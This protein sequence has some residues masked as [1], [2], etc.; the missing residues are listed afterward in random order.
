MAV[1]VPATTDLI[2]NPLH[3]FASWTYTWSLWWLDTD[4]HNALM[5]LGDVDT[6]MA[7]SPTYPNSFVVAED[8]GA[9]ADKRFPMDKYATLPPSLQAMATP[10]VLGLNYQIQ[11]VQIST[12]FGL[13][14]TTEHSNLLSGTMT[15]LE[16]YGVTFI[17]T[18]VAASWDGAQFNNY[19]QHPMML[20]LDFHGYD[21]A[22]NI[23]P[24]TATNIFRKRFPITMTAIK[25]NVS[26]KGAEYKIQFSPAGHAGHQEE[27][28][29]TPK[30]FQITAG[31]VKEFVDD[32]KQQFNDYYITEVKRGNA[33]YGD[34]IDFVIDADIASSTIVNPKET[35]LTKA[36][37]NTSDITLTKN[38]WAIPAGTSIVK[39]ITRLIS[40]TSWLQ[41]EQLGQDGTKA[42]SNQTNIT[43][44]IKTVASAK[45]QGIG[46]DNLRNTYPREFKYMV[47]QYPTWKG[48]H[49][50]MPTMPD[51]TPHTIK[52]YN[53]LYTGQNIDI[54]DLKLQFDTTYYT[55][56]LSYNKQLAA[57]QTT[58]QTGGDIALTTA[59]S[60]NL[61]PSS[62]GLGIP[63]L[64]SIPTL[65]PFRVKNLVNDR[66]ITSHMNTSG[67]PGA[68]VAADVMQST[69]S[70][71]N[72]DMLKVDLTIVGDPTLLKQDDWAYIPN[73]LTSSIFNSWDT[74]GQSD[75]ARSYGHV[76]TD[77]GELIVSLTINT[78]F[79][80]DTDYEG[81][82]LVYP[83]PWTKQSLFSGQYT[84]L[85]VDSTF[86]SGK[87]E[88]VLHLARYINQDFNKAF[89][90]QTNTGRVATIDPVKTNQANQTQ[91]NSTNSSDVIPYD[92][93]RA[94][95][96]GTWS[97]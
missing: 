4:D 32:F 91:S 29:K 72:G 36:D 94:G 51:S 58:A 57:T 5:D 89:A 63:E 75:F 39:V 26:N 37:S 3:Q 84:I 90:S 35:P 61:M 22:G 46:V 68:I 49:P 13:N 82:G 14:A 52:S 42:D 87:F 10:G 23:L 9:Y 85:K 24:D 60:I 97:I 2:P 34:S 64:L 86:R 31:T 17:D 76:R 71:L 6:A 43:N 15:V 62:L 66:N 80:I 77:A 56:V 69:F 11:D 16:P 67:S 88:Q 47:H 48:S 1:K 18:L 93:T 40:H 28:A 12:T 27:N 21:D 38:V 54:L 78:P 33:G 25:I 55:S 59:P 95:G 53:Y 65:T 79:D 41:N 30:N 73:P 45:I 20:Q 70:K 7:W 8:S 96:N 92:S 74:M 19:T 50:A 81:T 44:L 83:N